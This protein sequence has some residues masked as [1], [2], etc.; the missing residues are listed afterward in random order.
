ML[1]IDYPAA[2]GLVARIISSRVASAKWVSSESPGEHEGGS[3]SAM[4]QIIPAGQRTRCI[5]GDYEAAS[6]RM[7]RDDE[8]PRV[9]PRAKE[10][11][12]P[13]NLRKKPVSLQYNRFKS[14]ERYLLSA[15]L[16]RVE[17]STIWT[18]QEE[19]AKVE[20]GPVGQLTYQ[21]DTDTSVSLLPVRPR[22]SPREIPDE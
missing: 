17:R 19:L 5:A 21:R 6:T 22:R 2:F 10:K 3:W 16:T 8:P 1:I 15:T 13:C 4:R 18:G 12:N 20:T 11:K 14:F 7:Q 9:V